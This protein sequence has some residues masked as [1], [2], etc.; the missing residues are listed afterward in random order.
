MGALFARAP[1]TH[2]LL[3]TF[4]CSIERCPTAL[5]L[6]FLTKRE[7]NRTTVSHEI[8][9]SINPRASVYF[10]LLYKYN[11]LIFR[12]Q[13]MFCFRLRYTCERCPWLALW[14]NRR[15]SARRG[16]PASCCKPIPV[17]SLS[18]FVVVAG[19]T[20]KAFSATCSCPKCI[21]TSSKRFSLRSA[22]LFIAWPW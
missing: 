18:L 12:F 2:S 14:T 8:P 7:K 4:I 13:Y 16:A 15:S 11:T 1:L 9:S 19:G 17:C 5:W 21:T 3:P 10:V 20:A 6:F 22:F